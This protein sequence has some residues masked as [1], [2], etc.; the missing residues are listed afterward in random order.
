MNKLQEVLTFDR[1]V[2]DRDR[3]D[4]Y[5]RYFAEYYY[6]SFRFGQGTEVILN[7][8]QRYAPGGTWLDVGAGPATLFWGLVL[9]DI[10]EL[11]CTELYI[12][13]LK[14]L[15]DFI[16]SD[17][18]PQCY[19]D[20][21]NTYGIASNWLVSLRNLPR[22][23]FLYDALQPWPTELLHVQYD[24]ITA[25]GVFGLTTGAEDYKRC[26]SYLKPSLKDRGVVLGA[27]WIRS[28][29]FI[30]KGNTDNRFMELDLVVQA[31]EIYG[32]ELLH[33][34]QEAIHG[35]PNYDSVIV[36]ALR[37]PYCITL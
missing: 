33:I 11:H 4:Y 2:F 37:Q 30:D 28:Q 36:W 29:H 6:D 14:V 22:R 31:A 26:F 9:K 35:D 15:N 27:N 34:S 23:Y 24:L 18:V 21:M 8:I 17:V 3:I 1:A 7:V 5:M 32:Y 16:E 25:Y 10:R 12:E 19:R 20:V 13:G